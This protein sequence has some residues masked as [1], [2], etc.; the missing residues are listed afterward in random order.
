MAWAFAVN[1][2]LIFVVPKLLYPYALDIAPVML[3]GSTP[4][5]YVPLVLIFDHFLSPPNRPSR[6]KPRAIRATAAYTRFRY[7]E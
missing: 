2:A 6:S 1:R 7:S 4:G 5:P 3:T